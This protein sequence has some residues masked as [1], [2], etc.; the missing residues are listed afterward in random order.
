MTNRVKLIAVALLG[1]LAVSAVSQGEDPQIRREIQ[2]VYAKW[3]KLVGEGNVKALMAMIDP[4][5]VA[6]DA[7]GNTMSYGEVRKM[8]EDMLKSLREPK[9]KITVNQIQQQGDEVVAWVTMKASAKMKQGDKW[10]PMAF[11]M[12]FAETFKRVNGQWKFIASPL[13]SSQRNLR[14]S[15]DDFAGT[16]TRRRR[17]FFNC[18]PRES[19]RIR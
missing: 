4:S 8:F 2:A 18:A 10:V 3:D 11:T 12:K 7:E 16:L 9:S 6:T 1:A 5:F 17:S 19:V 13:R 15:H 14:D